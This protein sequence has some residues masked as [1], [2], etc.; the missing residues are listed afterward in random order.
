MHLLTLLWVVLF[1][2]D[3]LAAPTLS[4]HYLLS[5]PPRDIPIPKSAMEHAVESWAMINKARAQNVDYLPHLMVL[6]NAAKHGPA[7]VKEFAAERILKWKKYI[8]QQAQNK[9]QPMQAER[10][11]LI[12]KA[13][14]EQTL[15]GASV[16]K[17]LGAVGA[18]VVSAGTIGVGVGA[19]KE[20]QI[21]NASS[22]YLKLET[23]AI[24]KR[25]APSIER[26]PAGGS[27]GEPKI[28]GS[29]V[30]VIHPG[31]RWLRIGRAS[32]QFPLSIPH[33]IARKVAPGH[34]EPPPLRRIW[35]IPTP[36]EVK[37]LGPKPPQKSDIQKRL[38]DMRGEFTPHEVIECIASIREALISRMDFYG[39]PY[40]GHGSREAAIFNAAVKPEEVDDNTN[41][42]RMDWV[43]PEGD[44]FLGYKVFALANPADAGY[45][46]RWPFYGNSFNSRYYN[47]V[48]EVLADI[49][50]MWETA[51]SQDLRINAKDFNSYSIILMIPDWFDKHCVSHLVN[52]LLVQMKF[53]RVCIQQEGYAAC[54]GLGHS[55]A[56]VVDVGAV[57]TS[58]AC[59]EDGLLLSETRIVLDFGGDDVT[60]F[61]HGMLNEIAF[62]YPNAD[63]AKLSDLNVMDD[64]K[65]RMSTLLE[66]DVA[67]KAY[68][69]F[70]REPE[71]PTLKYFVKAYDEVIVAPM[72]LFEPRI[73]DFRAKRQANQKRWDFPS[74]ED[75]DL[76]SE[77]PT[78]AMR[79]S[80]QHLRE[81]PVL[82][83]PYEAS[84]LPMDVAIFN[85]A[86]AAGPE[87]SKKFLQTVVVVGGSAR[88]PGVIHALE[89]RLQA[90]A[91]PLIPNIERLSVVSAPR[92]TDPRVLAWRGISVLG[93][94]EVLNDM[95]ITQNEWDIL[96]MRCLRERS[97]IDRSNIRVDVA[98]PPP[99]LAQAEQRM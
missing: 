75:C 31:S 71:K 79:I 88:I 10:A 78:E 93:R 56:C 50:L 57:K 59:I 18:V 62:P 76:G 15:S 83:V 32:D 60:E 29:N 22:A 66:A 43:R 14:K 8:K 63:M 9:K 20:V 36:D 64:L 16:T 23:N 1:A 81:S 67:A 2:T 54:L 27:A 53:R 89:S 86:R 40:D 52:M 25:N 97:L 70:V 45:S 21:R 51:M 7:D 33:V 17:Q 61:M 96:G 77:R 35:K 99:P 37:A 94:L 4:S 30:I 49:Q 46:V 69:F 55:S 68:D 19:L 47:S 98:G 41:P 65:A 87:K 5:L 73:V 28:P 72:L 91:I 92:D 3:A 13:S 48:Q 95:W 44:V 80:T 24:W 11:R 39:I 12:L 58:V 26:E 90:I 34:Q 82:D 84:K 38:D 42:Y 85:S 6:K 74:I